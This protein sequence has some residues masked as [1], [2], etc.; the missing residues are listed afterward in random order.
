MCALLFISILPLSNPDY[1]SYI[2]QVLILDVRV[3]REQCINRCAILA[4]NDPE[5][6]AL[7]DSVIRGCRRDRDRLP[8][9][10]QILVGNLWVDPQDRVHRCVEFRGDQAQGITLDR[11][12]GLATGWWRRVGWRRCGRNYG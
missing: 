7:L 3:E 11:I 6:I 1:L 12:V 2:D 10:D 8:N 5:R 4:G 9:I